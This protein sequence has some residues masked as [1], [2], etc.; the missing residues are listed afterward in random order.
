MQHLRARLEK[1]DRVLDSDKAVS[2]QRKRVI[3]AI[4]EAQEILGGKLPW[5]QIRIAEHSQ[6]NK[7]GCSYNGK[8]FITISDKVDSWDDVKLRHVVWHELVHA[9]FDYGHNDKCPLMK[10]TI[11]KE[12]LPT[13]RTALTRYR[14]LIKSKPSIEP[15]EL[16]RRL[17]DSINGLEN[18]GKAWYNISIGD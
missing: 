9:Y 16:H 15:G 5:I 10:P 1:G 4:Y 13:L 2:D 8:Q 3:K 6:T 7:L 14:S 17:L 11:G 18:T 12:S